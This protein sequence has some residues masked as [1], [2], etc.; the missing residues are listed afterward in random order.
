MHTFRNADGL[1]LAGSEGTCGMRSSQ[2]LPVPTEPRPL[3]TLPILEYSIRR[4]SRV[5]SILHALCA[6]LRYNYIPASVMDG[7]VYV[8]LLAYREPSRPA[9]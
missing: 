4:R 7:S 1:A 6:R 2:I 8:A 5:I 9:H 3:S